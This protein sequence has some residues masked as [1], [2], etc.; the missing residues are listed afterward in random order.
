MVKQPW[1]IDF[2]SF[3]FDSELSQ[4]HEKSAWIGMQTIPPVSEE[5]L[6][7]I[8]INQEWIQKLAPIAEEVMSAQKELNAIME[9]LQPASAEYQCAF[10]EIAQ[11]LAEVSIPSVSEEEKERLLKSHRQW[12]EYGWTLHPNAIL[13]FFYQKPIDRADAYIHRPAANVRKDHGGFIQQIAVLEDGRIALREQ[14]HILH[15]N[16]I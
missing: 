8:R 2:P 15:E 3:N 9:Q 6:E 13:K 5:V 11:L 16:F 10:N 1:K 14:F 12:G 7:S 4:L